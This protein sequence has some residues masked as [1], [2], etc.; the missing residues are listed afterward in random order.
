MLQRNQTSPPSPLKIVQISKILERNQAS[1]FKQQIYL[2]QKP[3]VSTEIG[4]NIK[5]LWRKL[6]V[7]TKNIKNS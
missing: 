3:G 2:R 1:L 5:N 7:S 4:S 6:G